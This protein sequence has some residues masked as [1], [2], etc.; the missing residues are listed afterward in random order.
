MCEDRGCHVKNVAETMAS[1][2]LTILA[3]L[4][5]ITPFLISVCLGNVSFNARRY[6]SG[7]KGG[8]ELQKV[9][10]YKATQAHL[11]AVLGAEVCISFAES[12]TILQRKGRIQEGRSRKNLVRLLYMGAVQRNNSLVE[13]SGSRGKSSGLTVGRVH[14][15]IAARMAVRY[16]INDSVQCCSVISFC[17]TAVGGFGLEACASI[18]LL[19]AT[20]PAIQWDILSASIRIG[21]R[22]GLQV[23]A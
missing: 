2:V 21:T 6:V 17:T 9:L 20:A 7:P 13:F 4:N 3:R 18:L 14:Q 23:E 22:L 10:F 8:L 11:E 19:T 5:F 16:N 1:K 12:G 15:A